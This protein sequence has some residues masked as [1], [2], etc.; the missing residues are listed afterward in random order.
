MQLCPVAP[1]LPL[2][3]EIL[4]YQ[5]AQHLEEWSHTAVTLDLY[6]LEMPLW[7]VLHLETGAPYQCVQVLEGF[8]QVQA[9]YTVD[10]TFMCDFF[11]NVSCVQL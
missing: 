7:S 8:T 3:I 6:C 9:R 1:L 11:I 5:L 4:E 2:T 10:N